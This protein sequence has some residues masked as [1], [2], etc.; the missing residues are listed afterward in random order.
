MKAH[1]IRIWEM[2]YGLLQPERTD[3]NIRYYDDK[4][5]KKLLNVCALLGEG[6]KI[7]KIGDLTDKQINDE[8]EKIIVNLAEKDIQYETI[9][10]QVI[11]A[12]SSFDEILFEKIFSNAILRFGLIGTYL[13]VI[14]PLLVRIGLMWS[15]DDILPAQEHFLSRPGSFFFRKRKATKSDCYWPVIF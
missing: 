11:I 6:M 14:Y 1:T 15:K 5:L 3:T 4:Q 8:I 7:S 13:K 12:I 2:R 9:I 10:N